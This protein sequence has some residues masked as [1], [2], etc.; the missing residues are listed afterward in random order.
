MNEA[1]HQIAGFEG[2]ELIGRGGFAS[3][4][5]AR[6]PKFDRDVAIKVLNV[7][8]LDDAAK[9]RFEREQRTMGSL[10]SHPGIVTLYDSGFTDAGSPYLAMELMSTSMRDRLRELGALPWE[11]A[12][13][14]I[15]TV[16]D[17]VVQA[18]SKGV[19]HC[20]IKP[21]NILVSEFE[22]PKL[23]D[24][25]IATLI[26]GAATAATNVS[27]TLEY[28]PPEVLSGDKPVPS[29]DV[30][31]LGATLFA[32][33]SGRSPFKAEGGDVPVA[34]LGRVLA[35]DVPDLRPEGIPAPICDV[36]EAAMAKD[37]AD[38]PETAAQFKA[39]LDEAV[40]L[41]G[42]VIS[43]DGVTRVVGA[44]AVAA[45]AAA[46]GDGMTRRIDPAPPPG[47]VAA[48]VP[49]EAGAGSSGSSG[50]SRWG[51]LVVGLLALLVLI[52]GAA[53]AFAL[54]AGDDDSLEAR[55]APPPPEGSDGSFVL[56]EPA[57]DEGPNAFLSLADREEVTGT[58]N[59]ADGA[60]GLFGGTL[61]Q[62]CDQELLIWYLY[63][64]PKKGEAWAEALGITFEEI[65]AFVRGLTPAIIEVETRVT[66][67]GF[68]D[69]EAVPRQTYLEAGTAVLID[70]AGR[71]VVRCYCGN[72]LAAAEGPA[73][74][75]STCPCDTT[76][77]TVD[78]QSA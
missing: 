21:D 19:L 7:S 24:F 60:F 16:T 6:Q 41:A 27:A 71:P 22:E 68:E 72:P 50:W 64:F 44:G 38:R 39:M 31:A 17:A 73:P 11:Q 9:R 77:T 1:E 20:D 70:D 42:G 29:S 43:E 61:E 45:A 5:R 10:S 57:A 33:L 49:A 62:A 76:T 40:R 14:I 25:G 15:G 65:P 12:V 8:D 32:M 13:A 26:E 37:V 2:W 35:A 56:F 54:L 18:H 75:P 47:E 74:V 63:Q 69:G 51:R 30:Y 67:F 4:Y 78:G 52:L 48:P 66:N 58:T 46:G 34:V 55:Y 53:V 3:V 28:A 36:V 23:S 59:P